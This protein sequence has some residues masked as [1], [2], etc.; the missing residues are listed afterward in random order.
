MTPTETA[1]DQPGSDLQADR[2]SL[3]HYPSVQIGPLGHLQPERERLAALTWEHFDV[4][5]L[6][7][8]VGIP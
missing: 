4:R 1:P 8:T 6:S 2:V 7:A 3:P 5:P